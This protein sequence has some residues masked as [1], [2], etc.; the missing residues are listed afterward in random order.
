MQRLARPAGL[1]L[2]S[3]SVQQ[4]WNSYTLSQCPSP[5]KNRR[6]TRQSRKGIRTH[7]PQRGV[8]VRRGLARELGAS[9]KKES[10]FHG[11]VAKTG[12]VWLIKPAT[13]MNKSGPGRWIAREVLPSH[14]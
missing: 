1:K 8:L 7:A 14:A 5:S 2:T 9:F 6:R 12:G 3:N 13:F 4:F 11:E 10:K